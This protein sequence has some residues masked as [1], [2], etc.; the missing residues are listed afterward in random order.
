MISGPVFPRTRAGLW[1]LIEQ[2]LDEVEYGLTLIERDLELEPGHAVDALARDAGGFPVFLFTADA[3]SERD[4]PARLLATRGWLATGAPFLRR[5]LPEAQIDFEQV[6]RTVVVGFE[7]S[8]RLLRQLSDLQAA[9]VEAVR[10]CSIRIG[11]RTV[12]GSMPV[13]GAGCHGVDDSFYVPRGV[14]DPESKTV[15]ARFLELMRR[16]DGDLEIR[17]DRYSREFR[18]S[19]ETLAHVASSQNAVRVRVSARLGRA[20]EFELRSFADCE[21]AIDCVM[22]RYLAV[23]RDGSETATEPDSAES[24]QGESGDDFAGSLGRLR[25]T[26]QTS[27][28]TP[29]EYAALGEAGPDN[30]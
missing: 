2:H 9:A 12:V 8:P 5:M 4:L 18:C 17:G 7:I 28:I 24:R 25:E 11:G 26:V 13:L 14:T 29:E 19:G 16:V 21:E 6:P 10:V 22:R 20:T 3:D 1:G 23:L 30:D 27:H 15:C